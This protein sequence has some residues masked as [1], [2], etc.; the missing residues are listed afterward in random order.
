MQILQSISVWR[1]QTCCKNALSQSRSIWTPPDATGRTCNWQITQALL[2]PTFLTPP[3]LAPPPYPEPSVEQHEAFT[4]DKMTSWIFMSQTLLE[5]QQNSLSS[6]LRN[7]RCVANMHGGPPSLCLSLLLTHPPAPS[8]CWKYVH[9]CL[10]GLTGGYWGR[11]V[12]HF[13]IEE[14]CS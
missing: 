11:H 8:W 3:H 4:K 6:A 12:L 13:S 5:T 1:I 9:S 14:A 10:H 2:Y 7:P